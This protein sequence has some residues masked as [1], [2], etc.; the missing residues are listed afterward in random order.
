MYFRFAGK[1][2]DFELEVIKELKKRS[3]SSGLKSGTE[4]LQVDI[5]LEGVIER[6]AE[7]T[8]IFKTAV[9]RAPSLEFFAE[10][11]DLNMF[12]FASAFIKSNAHWAPGWQYVSDKRIDSVKPDLRY[13]ETFIFDDPSLYGPTGSLCQS[14]S[15]LVYFLCDVWG[16]ALTLQY[17]E[18][19]TF[20]SFIE[21]TVSNALELEFSVPT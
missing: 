5:L 3:G 1:K 6:Q 18:S 16:K 9:I 14:L 10:Q 21:V 11:M 13:S 7:D 8:F 12:T 19:E 15:F 20:D 17:S 4:P 2:Q